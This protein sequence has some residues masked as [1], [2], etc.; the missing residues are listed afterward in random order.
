MYEASHKKSRRVTLGLF[1]LF[2]VPISYAGDA[3]LDFNDELRENA[4]RC[5]VFNVTTY[6]RIIFYLIFNSA[7][8]TIYALYSYD[9]CFQGGQF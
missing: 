9:V 4:R 8:G 5:A 7:S 6:N 3:K 1:S 2:N